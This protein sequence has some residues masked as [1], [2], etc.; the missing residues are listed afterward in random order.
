MLNILHNQDN[1]EHNVKGASWYVCK[2]IEKGIDYDLI[3]P[4][5]LYKFGCFIS[6]NISS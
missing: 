3:K 5:Y 1:E 6:F 2:Y 4:L